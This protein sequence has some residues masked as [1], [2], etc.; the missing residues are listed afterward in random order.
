MTAFDEIAIFHSLRQPLILNP[1]LPREA[2]DKVEFV[3]F[4]KVRVSRHLSG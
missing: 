4:R 3:S 1:N 2:S